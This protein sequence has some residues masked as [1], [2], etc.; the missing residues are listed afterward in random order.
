MR[1]EN[2]LSNN[3]LCLLIIL[4][5]GCTAYSFM[6]QGSFKTLDDY[7]VIVYNDNIKSFENI[8]KIFTSS[9]FGVNAYYRPVVFLSYLL[10]YHFYEYNVFYYYLTHL[11]LHMGIAGL[12]F[13]F[14]KLFFKENTIPFFSPLYCLAYI[15]SSGFPLR[16]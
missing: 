12:V 6:L 1:K 15:Q 16:I 13:F 4:L 7:S 11:I 9:Y 8:D 10:E 2:F 5:L 3:L 14:L